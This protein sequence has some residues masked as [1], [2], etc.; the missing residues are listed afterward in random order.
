MAGKYSGGVPEAAVVQQ[1][2]LIA[3]VL[4]REAAGRSPDQG[5]NGER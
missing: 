3:E 1:D 5:G 2:W 4:R